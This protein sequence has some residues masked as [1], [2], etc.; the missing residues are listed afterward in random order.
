MVTAA[1]ATLVGRL[2][3]RW[4]AVVVFGGVAGAVGTVLHRA[5]QP[6]GVAACLLLVLASAVLARAWLG[7]VGLL[8][9]G[10][11][12]IVV[13]QALSLKGPGGDVLIPAGQGIGYVWLVGG[14]LMV[15]AGAFAP[16]GWFREVATGAAHAVALDP[17]LDPTAGPGA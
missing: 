14:M 5:Y 6:W 15:A 1:R 3:V 10:I 4:L 11:G 17:V 16:R 13:V 8:A 2:G 7:L 9:Y 12:W